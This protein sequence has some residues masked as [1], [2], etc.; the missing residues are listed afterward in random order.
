MPAQQSRAKGG[1]PPRLTVTAIV[2]AADRILAAEGPEKLS[3]RR[4]AS[5]LD[6]APMALYHHV[7]DKDHLLLLILEQHAEQISRPELP[8]DP[9]GE[10]PAPRAM[11]SLA[12]LSAAFAPLL[13][14]QL[15]G[16]YRPAEGGRSPAAASTPTSISAVRSRW[17]KR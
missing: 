14:A 3:M 2:A 8:T 11:A 12:L 9:D 4:L 6:S 10:S 5:E 16:L 15:A 7:R 13:L 1:R 17:R